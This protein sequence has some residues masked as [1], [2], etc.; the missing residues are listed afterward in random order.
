MLLTAL[1]SFG[2]KRFAYCLQTIEITDFD[3][4]FNETRISLLTKI[5][6][7][8]EIAPY[9]HLNFLLPFYNAELKN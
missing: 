5:L 1:F 3:R 8:A 2:S 9:I 6:T 7:N 4:S